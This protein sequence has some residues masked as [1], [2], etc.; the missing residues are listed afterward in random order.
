MQITIDINTG[1]LVQ[2]LRYDSRKIG[3]IV[4]ALTASLNMFAEAMEEINKPAEPITVPKKAKAQV[5]DPEKKSDKEPKE[6]KLVPIDKVAPKKKRTKEAQEAI[7]AI[8]EAYEKKRGATKPEKKTRNKRP[9]IDDDLIVQMRDKNGMKFAA[10]AKEVGCCEQTA[11]NRYNKAKN[12]G[13]K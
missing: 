6:V 7:D 5:K 8:K 9:D 12:G 4:G 2:V 1:T 11:I 10:I 13:S 3:I